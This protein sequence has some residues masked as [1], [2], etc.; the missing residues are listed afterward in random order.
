MSRTSAHLIHQYGESTLNPISSSEFTNALSLA[1]NGV[2]IVTTDGGAGKAGLTVSSMCSVCANP[3]IVLACV[4]AD[5][6]FCEAADANNHF[7]INILNVNQSNISS[8]F[9]GMADDPEQDR[10]ITGNWHKLVSGS[11]VLQDSLVSLDCKLEAATT[12]GT[13]RIYIGHV[14]AVSSNP[15]KPLVYSNR[16]YADTQPLE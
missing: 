10:F 16:A 1:A 15:G 3:A 4:N 13:H 2:S 5:N 6:F 7:A 14:L 12:H 11:P 9:A 8:V